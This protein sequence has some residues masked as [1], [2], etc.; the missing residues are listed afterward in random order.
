[1][2]K[3]VVRKSGFT[4]I[5][6]LVVIAIIAVLIALLLPAVQQA[7]ESARRTQCRNNMKQL[8]LALMNYE[9]SNQ[10]FP[11]SRINLSTGGTAPNLTTPPWP[12]GSTF[13]QS[14]PI[15]C[16]PQLDQAP[17][18][19]NYNA[20]LNWY[21]RANDAATTTKLSFFMC[22]SAPSDRNPNNA[23][24]YSSL[25]NGVRGTPGDGTTPIFGYADYGSL[26]AARN[27]VFLL[28]GDDLRTRP[29]FMTGSRYEEFSAFKRG[30]G[31]TAIA[32]IKDGTS[33]TLLL[34]EDAGR[35]LNFN[36]GRINGPNANN[37]NKLFTKDG[38]GWADPN[39]GCSM[40]GADQVTGLQNKTNKGTSNVETAAPAGNI[41]TY[42]SGGTT[43]GSCLINCNN[44]SEIYS[45]HTGGAMVM[46]ADG[47]VRFISENISP[48]TLAA[49][50]S[51]SRGDKIGGD[52]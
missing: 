3:T 5:E 41:S 14:W 13:V 15:M 30:P 18:Y 35:P 24:A 42:G 22:P 45:F 48:S 44:D 50:A 38:W 6:L 20:K 28:G 25:T 33:N 7:R 49:L 37:S 34:I 29:S 52:W 16:M 47:S 9:S 11:P 26:N 31:G 1:M 21:D 8:G 36:R 46:L 27:S 12:A 39:A 4:L 51:L 43:L 2:A 40:D 19:D 23:A 17:I 10:Q 32:E